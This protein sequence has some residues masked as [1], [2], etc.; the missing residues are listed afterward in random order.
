MLSEYMKALEHV[1]LTEEI[2]KG[3]KKY[4][5]YISKHKE[6]Y[7]WKLEGRRSCPGSWPSVILE[8]KKT[9]GK[10]KKSSFIKM[11]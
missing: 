8:S 7:G 1:F 9:L 11:H 4:K 2:I 5:F 6:H 3:Q 10:G